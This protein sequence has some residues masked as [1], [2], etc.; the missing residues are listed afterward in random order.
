MDTIALASILIA[1][2]GLLSLMMGYTRRHRRHGPL[3]IWAGVWCMLAVI[4][5]YILRSL[6]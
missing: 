1:F 5:Y 3:L 6:A 4:V 2:L